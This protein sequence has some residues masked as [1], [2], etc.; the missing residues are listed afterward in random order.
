[1]QVLLI[2]KIPNLFP[3]HFVEAGFHNF[4]YHYPVKT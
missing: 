1:M 3:G 2:T 4:T